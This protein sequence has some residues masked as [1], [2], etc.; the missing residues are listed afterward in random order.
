MGGLCPASDV[1]DDDDGIRLLRKVAE[2]QL[3]TG[4][5]Y[6]AHPPVVVAFANERRVIVTEIGALVLRDLGKAL[7]APE[8]MML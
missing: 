1:F 8:V 6:H 7:V 2:L 4:C 3:A 5:I